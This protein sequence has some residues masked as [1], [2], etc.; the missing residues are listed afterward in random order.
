MTGAP[1]PVSQGTGSTASRRLLHVA[2][3][4][5]LL[6]LEGR[7]SFPRSKLIGQS[8]H[9]HL[10]RHVDLPSS[11]PCPSSPSCARRLLARAPRSGFRRI[12]SL[13][14]DA[15][16]DQLLRLGPALQLLL[17]AVLAHVLLQ[18]LLRAD[19]ARRGGR[20][21]EDVA[22]ARPARPPVSNGPFVA[23]VQPWRAR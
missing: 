1:T 13:L 8:P 10:V 18:L 14:Q 4:L 6:A 2:C 5:R 7:T 9:L 19:D 15:L 17:Q 21:W 11:T 20:V 22:C 12:L 16:L 23:H 3:P